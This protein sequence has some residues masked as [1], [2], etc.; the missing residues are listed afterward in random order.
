MTNVRVIGKI[1][2]EPRKICDMFAGEEGYITPWSYRN[3]VLNTDSTISRKGG[4][5]TVWIRCNGD[6]TYT[7][8]FEN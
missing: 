4:T 1:P 3:G 7:I 8:K 2:P 6:D 5:S